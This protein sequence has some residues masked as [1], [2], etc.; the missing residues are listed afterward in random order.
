MKVLTPLPPGALQDYV[1]IAGQDDRGG[2]RDKPGKCVR[3]GV[4]FR[5]LLL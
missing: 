5:A 4:C 2:L 1:L 3:G